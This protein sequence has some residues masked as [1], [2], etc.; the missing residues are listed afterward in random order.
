[1]SCGRPL[2]GLRQLWVI[3]T[4]RRDGAAGAPVNFALLDVTAP[5][6]AQLQ[7]LAAQLHPAPCARIQGAAQVR[8]A[9]QWPSAGLAAMPGRWQARRA[10]DSVL[11]AYA[12]EDADCAT[13]DIAL[14]ELARRFA[15]N[16]SPVHVHVRAG[17]L[18][19]LAHR[20]ALVLSEPRLLRD[21]TLNERLFSAYSACHAARPRPELDQPHQH[22]WH[23]PAPEAMAPGSV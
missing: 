14:D 6:L 9:V 18:H 23:A 22:L 17:R 2:T 7:A 4:H 20:I 10:G 5:L 19:A 15:Q 3:E 1:M 12:L 16:A 13:C 8:P 11:V 21:A